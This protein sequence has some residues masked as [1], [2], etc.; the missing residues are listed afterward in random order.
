MSTRNAC[1]RMDDLPCV[2]RQWMMPRPRNARRTPDRPLPA[3]PKDSAQVEGS[4]I[5]PARVNRKWALLA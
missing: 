5:R 2:V 1:F 3:R 4:C